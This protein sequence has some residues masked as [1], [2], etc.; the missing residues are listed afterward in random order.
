MRA[1]ARVYSSRSH[2]ITKAQPSPALAPFFE[3]RVVI[4]NARDDDDES[5]HVLLPHF[6][7]VNFIYSSD[8]LLLL[9]FVG[10]RQQQQL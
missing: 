10:R 1:D 4:I 3:N 6:A 9:D 7:V 2:V 5:C 8:F